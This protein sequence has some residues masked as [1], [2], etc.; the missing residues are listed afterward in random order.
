MSAKERN[1]QLRR[2]KAKRLAGLHQRNSGNYARNIAVR[3]Q[4]RTPW[5]V[6]LFDYTRGNRSSAG[7]P[8]AKE[9]LELG[10]RRG[11]IDAVQDARTLEM[12]LAEVWEKP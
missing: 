6:H 7:G 5:N 12:E 8:L 11:A 9:A 3:H 4:K 1:E 10:M 2:G